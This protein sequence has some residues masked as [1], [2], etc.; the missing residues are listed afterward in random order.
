MEK[1]RLLIVDDSLLMRDII[2]ETVKDA[3]PEVLTSVANDGNEAQTMLAQKHFDLVLCDWEMPALNGNELLQWL[4]ERSSEKKVPFI[5]ITAKDEKE[6]ILEAMKL[7]VTDYIVKPF[8]PE[9]LC[10]KVKIA[11]NKSGWIEPS[12]PGRQVG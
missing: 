8:T 7:G 1:P 10:Q 5:M 3:F 2:Q 12:A 4:R 6:H 11:L 9:I